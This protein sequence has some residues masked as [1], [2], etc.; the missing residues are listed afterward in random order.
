MLMLSSEMYDVLEGDFGEYRVIAE[1]KQFVAKML[2]KA[3]VHTV[4]KAFVGM[5]MSSVLASILLA[6]REWERHFGT[7]YVLLSCSH[8][9]LT[10]FFDD[11]ATSG[12]NDGYLALADFLRLNWGLFQSLPHDKDCDYV[13]GDKNDFVDARL[14]EYGPACAYI[15]SNYGA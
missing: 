8:G 7:A 13:L 10:R 6:A 11:V 3:C 4:E 12:D 15:I 1:I 9:V 14:R 2:R 5:L